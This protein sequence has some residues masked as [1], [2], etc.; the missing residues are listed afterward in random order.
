MVEPGLR[1]KL[2]R[3]VGVGVAPPRVA[4]DLC[5]DRQLLRRIV[6]EVPDAA[7]IR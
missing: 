1:A 5:D 2:L 7:L 4:E 6:D 3:K